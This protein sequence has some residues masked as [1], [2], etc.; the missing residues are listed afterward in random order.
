MNCNGGTGGGD[1]GKVCGDGSTDS[2]PTVPNFASVLASND[3]ASSGR[4][5]FHFLACILRTLRVLRAT[6]QPSAIS[7]RCFTPCIIS[8]FAVFSGRLSRCIVHAECTT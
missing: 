6:S 5:T 3:A 4:S 8:L 1:S 2:V 7:S